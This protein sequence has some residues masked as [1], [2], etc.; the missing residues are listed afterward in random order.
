LLTPL[1]QSKKLL[2]KMLS[3]AYGESAFGGD[4]EDPFAG[5]A[6]DPFDSVN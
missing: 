3:E 2:K 1:A 5:D 4:Y 6:E